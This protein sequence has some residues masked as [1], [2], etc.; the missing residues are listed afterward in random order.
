MQDAFSFVISALLDLY[1]LAFLLRLALGLNRAD[2]RNPLAQAVL[3]A[4]NP[5]VIPARRFIPAA[6]RK[7][8]EPIAKITALLRADPHLTKENAKLIEEIVIGTYKR[9]RGS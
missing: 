3:K 4:T 2:F 5:L 1:V 9:L 7:D 6:G 8:A